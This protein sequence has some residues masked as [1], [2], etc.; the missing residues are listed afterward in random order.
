MRLRVAAGA[1]AS[2][3]AAVS[4]VLVLSTPA[5]AVSG[6]LMYQDMTGAQS[7]IVSP[8]AQQCYPLSEP[9]QFQNRTGNTAMLIDAT[10][11]SGGVV[12]VVSPGET[13]SVRPGAFSVVLF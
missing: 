13:A 7:H 10:D 6:E 2:A 8:D 11:C 1:A 12:A 9:R 4:G 5:S 3:V